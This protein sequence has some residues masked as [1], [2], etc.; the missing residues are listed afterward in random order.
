MDD[1]DTPITPSSGAVNW[2]STSLGSSEVMRGGQ[3]GDACLDELEG[4]ARVVKVASVDWRPLT[5]DAE[6]WFCELDWMV[7][8]V[9]E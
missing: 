4:S 8:G 6:R 7:D 3:G 9:R 1:G 2:G 5:H